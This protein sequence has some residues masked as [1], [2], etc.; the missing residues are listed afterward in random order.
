[1]SPEEVLSIAAM[2]GTILITGPLAWIVKEQ[3][4]RLRDLEECMS[5]FRVEHARDLSLYVEKDSLK[6]NLSIIRGQLEKL[7]SNIERIRIR[8]EENSRII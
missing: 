3:S 1:M 8:L 4:Q 5:D 2:V 6:D 7:E